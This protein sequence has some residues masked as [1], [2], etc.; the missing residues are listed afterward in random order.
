[1]VSERIKKGKDIMSKKRFSPEEITAFSCSP[2]VESV[3]TREIAFTSEFKSLA[4][5]ELQNGKTMKE[6]FE[7]NGINTGA[8]GVTRVRGFQQRIEAMAERDEGF[9]NLKRQPREK[10]KEKEQDLE[11]RVKQLEHNLAYARQEVEFLK[12][13]QMADM[14]ERKQW[15][16]KRQP[17]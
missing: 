8:L 7:A 4:Y 1:M 5:T 3:S 9:V 15:E 11:K 10:T 2:Y 6:I 13:I 16:S 12:K 17:K 14:E